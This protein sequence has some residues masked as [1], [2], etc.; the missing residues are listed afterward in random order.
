MK[1]DP[2]PHRY[3]YNGKELVSVTGYIKRWEQDQDWDSILEKSALKKGVDKTTLRRQWDL[4]GHMATIA[5]TA[6]HLYAEN[7]CN[8]CIT[9]DINVLDDIVK[10]QYIDGWL[11]PIS[12]KQ[13]AAAK[14]VEEILKDPNNHIVMTETKVFNEAYAGTFDL[15]VYHSD[16]DKSKEGLYIMDWKTNSSLINEYNR[17]NFKCLKSPFNYMFDE[18]KSVYAL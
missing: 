17:S 3:T 18:S 2:V 4:A 12:T 7:L 11:I 6:T 10:V 13:H 15:L 14:A 1:F 8:L 9:G 16:N 5:G